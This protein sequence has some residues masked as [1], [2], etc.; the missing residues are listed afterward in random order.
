MK[1][2]LRTYVNGAYK[3]HRADILFDVEKSRLPEAMGA[4]Q[5]YLKVPELTQERAALR[6]RYQE[7]R[8]EV[9]WIKERERLCGINLAREFG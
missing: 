7:L 8:S 1:A 4:V 5:N 2:T 3:K 6:K 9:I